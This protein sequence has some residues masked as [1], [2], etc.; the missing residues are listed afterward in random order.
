M[1]AE[2]GA[3]SSIPLSNAHRLSLLR[4]ER[5]RVLQL[6]PKRRGHRLYEPLLGE[7]QKH[8]DIPQENQGFPVFSKVSYGNGGVS[9]YFWDKNDSDA[10]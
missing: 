9:L 3:P 4:R 6:G 10:G 8:A 5:V 7:Y 1:E 2:L